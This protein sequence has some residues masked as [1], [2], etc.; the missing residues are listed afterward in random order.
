[1]ILLPLL[2][3]VAQTAVPSSASSWSAS[4]WIAL[5]TS[6]ASAVC[7]FALVA[8]M[9]IQSAD[10]Q[11][12]E[13]LNWVG[14]YSIRY[15]VG[16]DG[17][18]ALFVLLI[19]LLSPV[20]IASEWTRKSGVRGMHGL[21]LLLQFAFLGTVCA[22]D[23]FLLFFFWGASVIPFYFLIGVWGGKNRE[24]AAFQ[25]LVSAS[26][27][28]ALIFA[29]VVLIYYSVD[30][31]TF[32]LAE[33]AGSKL[34]GKT[35][36][37]LGSEFAVGPVAFVFLSLG[38]AL[39]V[40]VWPFHGWLVHSSEEAPASTFVAISSGLIPVACYV[41]I[42]VCY[43]LIPDT[44]NTAAPYLVAFGAANLLIGSFSA[45]AQKTMRSLLAYIVVAQ[46]GLFFIGVGSLSHA[47]VVGSIYNQFALALGVASIGL[48][49]GT[50][51]G[52]IGS[53]QFRGPN[54]ET[55]I[56]G[57]VGKAPMVA[58][59]CGIALASILGMPGL[60]GFVGQALVVLGA[61]A[62]HPVAVILAAVG[63][64]LSVYTLL[65]M[66]RCLFLGAETPI[67]NG[68]S[69]LLTSEKIYFS[70]LL[71]FMLVIGVY[72]KPFLEIVRPTVLTLISSIK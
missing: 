33:L 51:E 68:V 16:I 6:I 48:L 69:D 9:Q 3:A 67:S 39:R 34:S 56:S 17:L 18:N 70:S 2:G 5:I 60:G 41:F 7:G 72:P 54:N 46:T 64:L 49:S 1:M 63:L 31:H 30:P 57:I 44:L 52:R 20:L 26:I 45:L 10:L 65:N 29:A 35:F 11:F 14:S 42:R 71:V 22:Q 4:R 32:S 58:I 23:L 62:G 59:V 37:I 47:G 66:F 50:I 40:A 12:S 8:A 25:N 61:Y 13:V 27:G 36:E 19:S 28:N 55:P 43:P 53:S 24:R 38:I 15:E 21:L